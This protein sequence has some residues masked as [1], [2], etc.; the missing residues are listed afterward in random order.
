MIDCKPM[1][2]PMDP[3]QK[4]IIDQGEV[5]SNLER[6]KRLV[7]KLIYLTIIRPNLSFAVGVVG[8]FRQNPCID[9]WNVVIR[10]LK[11]LKKALGQG[12]LYDNKGNTQIFG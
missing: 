4:L 2:Y 11:Y 1:D 6:Y 12:I 10:I 9:H 8:Q 5:F 7:G 3:N